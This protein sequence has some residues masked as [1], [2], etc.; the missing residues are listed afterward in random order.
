[1]VGLRVSTNAGEVRVGMPMSVG[2]R[3]I[4]EEVCP[5]LTLQVGPDGHVTVLLRT[6]TDAEEVVRR[7]RVKDVHG[8]VAAKPEDWVVYCDGGYEERPVERAGWGWVVVTGG[9][10][11]EDVAAQEVARACGPVEL[12]PDAH[13]YVGASRLSNNSAEGQ[14]LAEALMWVLSGE[15]P[16]QG[17]TV[18]VR[19][20][21]T[22]VAG[23]AMGRVRA[24]EGTLELATA[25]RTLWRLVSSRWPLGWAHVKGHSEHRW[26]T[27][28]DELATR[29]CAGE[30]IGFSAGEPLPAPRTP[31]P[32]V[33]LVSEVPR[34]VWLVTRALGVELVGSKVV[35]ST[36]LL[37]V[38][39]VE[40]RVVTPG[41]CLPLRQPPRSDALVDVVTAVVAARPGPRRVCHTRP[42]ALV[43]DADGMDAEEAWE[44]VS[45]LVEQGVDTR[46][47]RIVLPRD[48]GADGVRAQCRVHVEEVIEADVLDITGG[49][50]LPGGEEPVG[51]EWEVVGSDIEDCAV[52]A[53]SGLEQ[54][55]GG[56]ASM[57][58]IVEGERELEELL[59]DVGMREEGWQDDGAGVGA[60]RLP[61]AGD[62][63][64]VHPAGGVHVL[65]RPPSPP[66]PGVGCREAV[67]WPRRQPFIRQG[68]LHAG[69]GEVQGTRESA[70]R[71]QQGLGAHTMPSGWVSVV[72]GWAPDGT[73]MRGL[74]RQLPAD[75]V[76]PVPKRARVCVRPS[77]TT[78]VP[79]NVFDVPTTKGD[80][81]SAPVR[82]SPYTLQGDAALADAE[83]R[84]G[85]AEL[86]DAEV[87]EVRAL[88][89]DV[90]R[91]ERTV[92]WM[93]HGW[94]GGFRAALR[95]LEFLFPSRRKGHCGGH[96]SPLDK[97]SCWDWG[98]DPG[99]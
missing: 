31:P 43:F 13:A 34:Y 6:Q 56:E 5:R 58:S 11:G 17:A 9:D 8:A 90:D 75:I 42:Q 96:T 44:W 2:V 27:L 50:E 16:P 39:P 47:T 95:L 71:E 94:G 1:M 87:R 97:D 22:L 80:Y 30:V 28:A 59:V 4:Q 86:A 72:T 14:G 60:W 93:G 40:V 38:R 37:G 92:R 48:M 10:G 74:V 23:W 82:L 76:R 3:S 49:L 41:E 21:N 89:R 35:V 66:L 12:E 25:L 91:A 15:G 51:L 61:H 83:V 67:F 63:V 62:I 88:R 20:D 52:A 32:S 26:N 54:R 45:R 69:D 65:A 55:D 85:D 68:V 73:E 78:S 79:V 99:G 19:T 33:P 57:S 70:P 98:G 36:W 84:E 81:V 64:S 7:A 18:L 46:V 53:S 77:Q 24:A 29:A